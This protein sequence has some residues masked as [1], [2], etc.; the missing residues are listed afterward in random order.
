MA[1]P[2]L[3]L[4]QPES[5]LLRRMGRGIGVDAVLPPAPDA[6]PST[7]DGGLP[8]EV[9]LNLDAVEPGHVQARVAAEDADGLWQDVHGQGP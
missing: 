7:F 8:E 5:R 6:A 2:I 1:A 4:H 9:L 3:C